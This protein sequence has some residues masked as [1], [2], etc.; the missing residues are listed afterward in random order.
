[1]A[2]KFT[3]DDLLRYIYNETTVEENILLAK[4]LE[5]DWILKETYHDLIDSI[6]LLGKVKKRKPSQSSIDIILNFSRK[7]EQETLEPYV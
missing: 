1:M 3:S 7:Q 6:D 2:H 4:A 5:I